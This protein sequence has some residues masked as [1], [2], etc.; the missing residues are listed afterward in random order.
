[1]FE[2]HGPVDVGRSAVAL[3]LDG[4]D[5]VVFGQDGHGDAEAE[6]DGEQAAVEQDERWPLTA[7]LEVEVKPVDIGVRHTDETIRAGA[8]H[9]VW[10]LAACGAGG[11]CGRAGGVAGVRGDLPYIS[12]RSW[13][14]ADDIRR[15][16]AER[17]GDA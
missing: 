9:R 17:Q 14:Y 1:M 4:D 12:G 11:R 15:P 7:L 10:R 8:T 3:E 16:D 6:L 13:T 5:A 2:G